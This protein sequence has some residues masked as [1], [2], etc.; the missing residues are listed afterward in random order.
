MVQK[1]LFLGDLF[2]DYK[3][4]A[5]DIKVIAK[6]VKENNFLVVVNMEGGIECSNS[7]AIYKRGPNLTNSIK[8]VDILKELNVVGVCL[9]NNHIMDYGDD[10]LRYTLQILDENKI[11]HTGAGN[12]FAEALKP[13]IVEANGI[14]VAILN[15]GWDVE[16]TIYATNSEAGCA[17]RIQDTILKEINIAKECYEQV[18]VCLHWG[19]EYNRLP[20]PVD[21]DLG[22]KIIE[23]GV[24][25]V[26]GHHPHCIQPKEN[27]MGKK[28][29]YSL[30]NFYFSGKR[31]TFNKQFKEKV[32]NQSDYGIAVIYDVFNKICTEQVIRYDSFTNQSYMQNCN[33]ELLEDIS[34]VDI[35]SKNYIKS[36]NNRKLNINPVLTCNEKK[37]SKAL[38]RLSLIYKAK[39]T[40][41]K[42]LGREKYVTPKGTGDQYTWTKL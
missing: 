33:K 10:A 9:A 23:H 22:H 27:Y 24:Q 15:F 1:I 32:R 3:Y 42:I 39:R 37:N 28:I 14:K 21:I 2:Y 7:H 16:E 18:I 36:A 26:I 34:G 38:K 20:M 29:F 40:A 8:V 41:K 4:M 13:M 11:L 31:K 12:N 35:N 30:G 19:F 17:P 5:D 25:L 6:W